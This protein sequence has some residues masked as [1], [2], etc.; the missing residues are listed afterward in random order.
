MSNQ[1]LDVLIWV[2]VYVGLLMVCLGFFV[3]RSA[4]GLGVGLVV[5]GALVAAIGAFLVWLRAQ[6]GP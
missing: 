4:A 2:M 1:R 3:Q 6:R 5:A